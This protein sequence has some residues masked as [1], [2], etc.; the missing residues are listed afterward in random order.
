MPIDRH[1]NAMMIIIILSSSVLYLLLLF[2]GLC[3][4]VNI[5]FGGDEI[6]GG[7]DT[8]MRKC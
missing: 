4:A 3:F 1:G 8:D 7:A 2:I 6:F 5:F